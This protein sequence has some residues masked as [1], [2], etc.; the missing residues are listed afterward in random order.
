MPLYRFC[1]STPEG[2][3]EMELGFHE[4]AAAMAYAHRCSGEAEITVWRD[5]VQVRPRPSTLLQ[6]KQLCTA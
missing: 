2:A 4:D 5:N 6:A 1:V 3:A